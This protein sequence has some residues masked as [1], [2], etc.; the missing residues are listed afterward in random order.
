[1]Q[2]KYECSE[3]KFIPV[4]GVITNIDGVQQIDIF[5]GNEQ[6]NS[7]NEIPVKD[8]KLLTCFQIQQQPI[9][10]KKLVLENAGI[11][12]D[13]D[14]P[15]EHNLKRHISTLVRENFNQKKKIKMLNQ[16][17][18]RQSKKILSLKSMYIN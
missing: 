11:V 6:P 5:S 18:R 17:I 9:R 1:M 3:I 10:S 16:Q 12:C 7:T 8:N 13:T 15:K 4:D 14:T 2:A